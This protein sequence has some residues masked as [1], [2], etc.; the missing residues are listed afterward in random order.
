MPDLD[1][2]HHILTYLLTHDHDDCKTLF[3]EHEY[4]TVSDRQGTI[5]LNVAAKSFTILLPA[6]G[7]FPALRN[8]STLA[9]GV[10]G[11]VLQDLNNAAGI[12]YTGRSF[13]SGT[14]QCWI[15]QY[16]PTQGNT[17]G[18]TVVEFYSDTEGITG[19]VSTTVR[20][21]SCMMYSNQ[22]SISM[23]PIQFKT[24]VDNSGLSGSGEWV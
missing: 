22:R 17:I 16:P 2:T 15:Q 21:A 4:A 24:N 1:V 19:V 9:G 14:N 5:T 12:L 6:A 3:Q 20:T 13:P 23:A 18:R 10:P 11:T 7:G 8:D